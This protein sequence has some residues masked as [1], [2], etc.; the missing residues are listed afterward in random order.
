MKESEMTE[1]I[2]GKI[3]FSADE[4]ERIEYLSAIL[5]NDGLRYDRI[6]DAEEETD[7]L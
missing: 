3:S 2:R 7:E 5:E 1:L 6:L 4:G